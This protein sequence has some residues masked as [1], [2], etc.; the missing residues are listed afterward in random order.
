MKPI[1]VIL[2]LVLAS[3]A[4]VPRAIIPPPSVVA[5]LDVAPVA[6]A[7]KATGAAVRDVADAGRASREAGRKVSDA[8]RRLSESIARAE[9][10][11]VAN[12]EIGKALAE[13]AAL[14]AELEA[15][16]VHLTAAHAFAEEKERVALQTIAALDDELSLLKANA[17]AQAVEIRHAAA[18]ESTLREQVEAL[19][20]NADKRL[21][22]EEKLRWWRKSAGLTWAF[23][24]VYLI[25][26]IFGSAIA[27]NLRIR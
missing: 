21:I 26:K 1:A 13:T 18:T 8:T 19:A 3:C 15:E 24:A 2:C 9:A 16:V 14:A 6:E 11:A 23:L 7:G 22:A 20:A 25:V 27:A 17:K 5:E 4:P 10:L 12:V